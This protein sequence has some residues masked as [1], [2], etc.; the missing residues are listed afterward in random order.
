MPLAWDVTI[1]DTYAE[2]H[3]IS[4]STEARAAAKRAAAII[5][6]KYSDITSTHIFYQIFIKTAGSWD[7]QAVGLMEETGRWTTAATNDQNETMY[8]FQR[9]SMA[10]QRG[11]AFSFF[12]H[13]Q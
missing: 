2:S 11:N 13:I 7:V 10:I 6:T 9:I 5:T 12:S 1:P 4:M 3:I 8:L